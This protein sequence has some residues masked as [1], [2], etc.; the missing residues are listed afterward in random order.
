MV[1]RED[2][3]ASV[4]MA[5]VK[6]DVGLDDA[7]VQSLMHQLRHEGAGQLADDLHRS[8]ARE[9]LAQQLRTEIAADPSLRRQRRI[10]LLDR[11]D[12]ATAAAGAGRPGGSPVGGSGEGATLHAVQ[13]LRARANLAEHRLDQRLREAASRAATTLQ[14]TR[15]RFAQLRA[16]MP[17]GRKPRASTAKREQLVG[18]PQDPATR[19]ALAQLQES[20][21]GTPRPVVTDWTEVP[22]A[23]WPRVRYHADSGRLEA[24]DADGE[25]VALRAVPPGVV[26]QLRDPA[27][28]DVAALQ[29]VGSGLH[30]YADDQ[31]AAAAAGGAVRCGQCGQFV[32]QTHTCPS[33]GT[34]R[35]E[36]ALGVL[37]TADG[38]ALGRFTDP[39]LVLEALGE[40]QAVR[41]QVLLRVNGGFVW[42]Q[43]PNPDPLVGADAGSGTVRGELVVQSG[44]DGRRAQLAAS[45]LQCACAQCRRT[46]RCR[47]TA[48]AQRLALAQ[49]EDPPDRSV[50]AAAFERLDAAGAAPPL[51]A[52]LSTVHFA[53]DPR[54][55]AGVVREA[56]VDAQDDPADPV[57]LITDGPA[58]YGYGAGRR[59]G[60]EVEYVVDERLVV[61]FGEQAG[62][63]DLT[64]DTVTKQEWV[65]GEVT[66]QQ[67]DPDKQAYVTRTSTGWVEEDVEVP[68]LDGE[69]PLDD[70]QLAGARIGRALYDQGLVDEPAQLEYGAAK[71][72]GYSSRRWSLEKDGSVSGEIVSSVLRDDP[73]DWG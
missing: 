58:L 19:Q 16:G 59:F 20:A 53:Q 72:A 35:L 61:A 18:L 5:M 11:L 57:P 66:E 68:S 23:F 32:G 51:P 12:R 45:E 15:E 36:G 56:L 65:Q 55:F 49:L 44:P 9:A 25:H 17:A 26:E 8:Q 62:D 47:H 42:P 33:D 69:K 64:L 22:G 60:V 40:H 46:G 2:K 21:A 14:E 3:L 37:R 4:A 24:Q 13:Q 39:A 6:R 41:M 28:A 1:C 30:R 52:D 67:W 50:A 43:S 38:T 73:E 70:H 54:A 48:V 71:Y 27:H 31:D 29:V 63:G 7:Q 34:T 10:G